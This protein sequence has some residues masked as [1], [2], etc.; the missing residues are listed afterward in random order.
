[1]KLSIDG[2]FYISDITPNDKAAY[3]EHLTEK[4]IYDQTLNIPYPYTEKDANW[5]INHISE[6][7]Q[8]QGKSVNWAIRRQDGYLVGGIGYHGLEVGKTH[9]AEL[10]Y[11]LCKPYWGKGLMTQAVKK[12]VEFGLEELGLIR[13][14]AHIFDFN[15]G[16]ARVLEKSGFQLEGHLRKNYKKDGK[17]FDGKLYAKVRD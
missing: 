11:W 16:S 13:I 14:T 4:Q 1:M 3:L 15:T 9:K 12:V 10:G 2:S 8:K 7:T 6:E 5:W 17:I